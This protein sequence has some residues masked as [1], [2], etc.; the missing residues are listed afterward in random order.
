MIKIYATYFSFRIS[1][2]LL[3]LLTI[4]VL[5][6]FL[7]PDQYGIYALGVGAIAFFGSIFFQWICVSV[8]RFYSAK[9]IKQDELIYEASVAFVVSAATLA[10]LSI[11]ASL[12]SVAFK[13]INPIFIL[14]V[15]LG[16]V[17]TGFHSLSLQL[18]NAE[19]SHYRY[20]LLGIS[21]NFFSL[22]IVGVLSLSGW[23]GV[24]SVVGYVV[25]S[26]LSVAIFGLIKIRPI[27]TRN[28][29]VGRKIYEYGLPLTIAYSAIMVLDLSDRFLIG[30][31]MGPSAVAGYAAAYDFTQQ[32]LGA[33]MNLFFVVNFP[34]VVS[35]WESESKLSAKNAMLPLYSTLLLAI[36]L[37]AGV[38]LGWTSEISKMVF[39]SSVR[40]E[41]E[42]IIP[43]IA[44]A[45]TIGSIKS[46]FFDVALQLQRNS[47]VQII[48]TLIMALSNVAFTVVLLK[49]MG[50]VG[51]AMATALS[52]C[53][54][55][56]ISWWYGR[57]LNLYPIRGVEALAMFATLLITVV[58]IG[59]GSERWGQG[60]MP[61]ILRLLQGVF[62][63]MAMA[64][65]TNLGGIREKLSARL[66][67]KSSK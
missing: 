60:W 10:A 16:A 66:N 63:Y 22:I 43:W 24:I 21:R 2:G 36:P 46:Y 64:V 41:A 35:A 25:A 50:T 57:K 45:I 18:A 30:W 13:N 9:E 52:F 29:E 33:I 62:A 38:F 65:S 8:S 31:I 67:K 28:I 11:I 47:R 56:I 40:T 4:Y 20:G 32:S 58:A 44:I 55:A 5:T 48:I 6:R 26:M 42:K 59:A 1:N 53:I 34:A 49:K 23:G 17:T 27:K 15:C 3:G 54:G 12:F 61:D 14:V 37:V 19:G 39:G 7:P 51:A